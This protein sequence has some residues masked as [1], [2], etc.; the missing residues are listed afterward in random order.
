MITTIKD[1]T[2]EDRLG[3]LKLTSLKTRRYR[4]DLIEVFKIFKVL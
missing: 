1:E 4:D 3:N 2:Y